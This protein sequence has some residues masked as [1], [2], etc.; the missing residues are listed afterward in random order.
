LRVRHEHRPH[1][2]EGERRGLRPPPGARGFGPA[3]RWQRASRAKTIR[4]Y[5]A[6]YA[7]TACARKM[8]TLSNAIAP[9]VNSTMV[10]TYSTQLT[11]RIAKAFRLQDC[12]VVSEN[13]FVPGARSRSKLRPPEETRMDWRPQVKGRPWK[14]SSRAWP[15]DRLDRIDLGQAPAAELAFEVSAERDER[16][17]P[18]RMKDSA[19]SPRAP[20]L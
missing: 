4:C 19:S 9:I 16:L 13:G 1:G 3:L 2:Q 11:G 6:R 20:A 7:A 14:A 12:V 17:D 8:P 18:S 15:F 5:S 10:R